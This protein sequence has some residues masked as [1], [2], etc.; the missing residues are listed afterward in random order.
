VA[1]LELR[2][3]LVHIRVGVV[4][5]GQEPGWYQKGPETALVLDSPEEEDTV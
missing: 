2:E 5:N 3:M 1:T 4:D